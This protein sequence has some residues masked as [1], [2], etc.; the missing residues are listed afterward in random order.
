[1]TVNTNTPRDALSSNRARGDRLII[2]IKVTYWKNTGSLSPDLD[3]T[4]PGSHTA[5]DYAKKAKKKPKHKTADPFMHLCHAAV[6]KT[7]FM[8]SLKEQ[9]SISN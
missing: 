9:H 4:V 8:S 1:M 5:E 7:Q 3:T 6:N 2:S